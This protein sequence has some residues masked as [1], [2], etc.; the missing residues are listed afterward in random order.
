MKIFQERHPAVDEEINLELT[1]PV[2]YINDVQNNFSVLAFSLFFIVNKQF[3]FH[4]ATKN[5]IYILFYEVDLSLMSLLKYFVE[6][7]IDSISDQL[8]E[9]L[10]WKNRSEE[11]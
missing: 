5:N 10:M 1:E 7:K 9:I 8:G 3:Y 6:T 2:I 11:L 4:S